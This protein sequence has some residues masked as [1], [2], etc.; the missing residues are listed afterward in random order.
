MKRAP[1]LENEEEKML[2]LH[3]QYVAFLVSI[4]SRATK[5]KG[6]DLVRLNSSGIEFETRSQY[7]VNITKVRGKHVTS[8]ATRYVTRVTGVLPRGTPALLVAQKV[9]GGAF[10]LGVS[11]GDEDM[12]IEEGLGAL[13]QLYRHHLQYKCLKCLTIFAY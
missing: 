7:V 2:I 9:F 1:N 6:M 3:Q 11:A 4:Y 5:D 10:A 8:N 12:L 13:R